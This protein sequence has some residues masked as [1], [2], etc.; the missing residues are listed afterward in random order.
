MELEDERFYPA[1]LHPGAD[2]PHVTDRAALNGIQR[3]IVLGG[4]VRQAIL[5]VT[6]VAEKD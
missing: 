1:I 3:I 6:L 5:R 4:V 2:V